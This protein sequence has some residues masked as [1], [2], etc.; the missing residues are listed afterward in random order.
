M[1][2]LG[3]DELDQKKR[4]FEYLLGREERKIKSE[5]LAKGIG[6]FS[7]FGFAISVV[8][9]IILAENSLGRV[10]EHFALLSIIIAFLMIWS[11]TGSV[12]YRIKKGHASDIKE[13]IRKAEIE[14]A[15]EYGRQ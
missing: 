10:R 4:E 12:L 14:E 9:L 8:I 1:V 13:M 5:S 11:I 15:K 6:M 3:S 7:I 2:L